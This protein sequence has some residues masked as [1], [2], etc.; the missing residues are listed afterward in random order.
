VE[1]RQVHHD[2]AREASQ[3]C[4]IQIEWSVGGGDHHHS[5]AFITYIIQDEQS[6]IISSYMHR[7]CRVA[8]SS[9]S[10]SLLSST[11]SS[12]LSLSSLSLSTIITITIT[13]TILINTYLSLVVRSPSH[14]CIK[15][16]LTDV[17][18]PVLWN[19]MQQHH[20]H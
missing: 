14:S 4:L 1:V 5:T 12:L 9:T 20:Y 6:Y 17:R 16:V 2:A 18:V 7:R 3:H 11:S 13:T 10:S 19:K 15:V 8:L